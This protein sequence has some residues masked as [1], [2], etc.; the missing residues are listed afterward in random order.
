MRTLMTIIALLSLSPIV[1][2]W[3]PTI[4]NIQQQQQRSGYFFYNGTLTNIQLT[5]D[6]PYSDVVVTYYAFNGGYNPNLP[7]K[8]YCEAKVYLLNPN[9]QMA[10]KYSLTHY[11]ETP[12]G[13]VYFKL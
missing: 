4:T 3:S 5:V 10:V 6:K 7:N 12:V 8:G 11:A 2:S 1:Q 13:T 9:N